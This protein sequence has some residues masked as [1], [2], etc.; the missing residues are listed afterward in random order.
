MLATSRQ[1]T[2]IDRRRWNVIDRR[3]WNVRLPYCGN[4]DGRWSTDWR[5]RNLIRRLHLGAD[6]RRATCRERPSDKKRESFATHGG[7]PPA[8]YSVECETPFRG[9]P[10][11]A[12]L[13]RRA[14]FAG[15]QVLQPARH[16]NAR[17]ERIR[18]QYRRTACFAR[19][20]PPLTVW[21]RFSHSRTYRPAGNLFTIQTPRRALLGA[22]SLASMPA[23]MVWRPSSAPRMLG[24]QRTFIGRAFRDAGCVEISLVFKKVAPA[25]VSVG[26]A[27]GDDCL[28]PAV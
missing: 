3:R 8:I 6:A 12:H 15:S 26:T 7:F 4:H 16:S 24:G 14:H 19:F 2:P 9:R 17:G 18:G 23:S 1:S 20:P 5:R 22:L 13:A 10:G 11:G 21:R 27:T 25:H 28:A